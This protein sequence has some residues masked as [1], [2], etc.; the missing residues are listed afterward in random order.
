MIE[1]SILTAA[2]RY[3]SQ[4]PA[5]ALLGPRQVGKTTLAKQIAQTREGVYFDLERSSDLQRLSDP[6]RALAAYADK[7]VVLDEVQ[8]MPELFSV[9]RPLIDEQRRAGR[10]LLLGSASETLLSQ[11]SET[12][13]GRIG[14]VEMSGFTYAE[15][16]TKVPST[17]LIEPYLL[18]GGFPQS[19]LATSDL[20]SYEWRESFIRTFLERDIPQLG[21]RF[22][23]PTLQRFWTMVA[24][25]HGQ[26]WNA[27]RIA[28]SM[29]VSAVAVG[30]YIDALEGAFMLRRLQ[31]L[32]ANT[33]KRL[34]KSPKVYLRDTGLLHSLLGVV[35]VE[36][37]QAHPA[38]GAVWEGMVIEQILAKLPTGVKAN[39]YRT[40]RGAEL[41]LVL[42]ARNIYIAIECKYSSAPKVGRGYH[43][44]MKDLS[45]Q[46]GYLIAPVPQAYPL[47]QNT[48]VLPIEDI[49]R[50]FDAF[51]N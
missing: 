49:A 41:D 24:H 50:V 39:Y 17:T 48:T 28:A 2:E 44:A 33:M 30:R 22:P 35:T 23:A 10:F 7:L 14:F 40:V 46:H 3:L 4:F 37:M 38:I 15:L 26:I 12:L 51:S 31:P 43:E 9:L 25:W 16:K 13:A 45:A 18:R 19:W 8:R 47:T 6:E 1:R 20:M 5:L 11:A 32:D 42:H 21:F 27:S 36:Q 29:G 34:I